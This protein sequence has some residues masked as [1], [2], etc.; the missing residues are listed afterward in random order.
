M[1]KICRVINEIIN[2]LR[3]DTKGLTIQEISSLTKV[4]RITATKALAKLEREGSL[5]IR[6]IGN[7]KLHYSKKAV[8]NIIKIQY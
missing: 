5:Y 4:S 6:I 7:C 8:E 1:T 3:K 2:I